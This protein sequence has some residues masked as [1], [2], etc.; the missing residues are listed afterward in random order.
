MAQML[1]QLTMRAHM[2]GPECGDDARNVRD[3]NREKRS[4]QAGGGF[5]LRRRHRAETLIRAPG[6]GAYSPGSTVIEMVAAHFF[7]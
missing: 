2:A 1:I 7:P 4:V 6:N 5:W 3:S